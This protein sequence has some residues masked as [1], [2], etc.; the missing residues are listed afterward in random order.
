MESQKVNALMFA[1]GKNI[2]QERVYELQQALISAPDERYGILAAYPAKDP[3][4][5]TLMSVF[6][7]TMGIDRFM[8]GDIGLGLLKLFTFGVC[9]I[10]W[11]VDL[12]LV[13]KRAKE[14]N[15]AE[16]MQRLI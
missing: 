8:I 14:K 13:G 7:G 9:G 15:F 16:I 1:L 2:P 5:V 10:M 11:F 3:V 6:L 12:F 4:V